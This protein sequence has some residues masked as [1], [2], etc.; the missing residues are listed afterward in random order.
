MATEKNSLTLAIL[1]HNNEKFLGSLLESILAQEDKSFSILALNNGSTDSSSEIMH[2]YTKR[3]KANSLSL[4]FLSS[5]DNLGEAIG[6]NKLASTC[7]TD[8]ISIIH[9]DDLLRDDYTKVMNQAII[10]QDFLDLMSPTLMQIDENGL[11]GGMLIPKWSRISWVNYF[12][13]SFGNP[14]LMPGA[15]FSTKALLSCSKVTKELSGLLFNADSVIWHRMVL[16]RPQIAVVSSAIYFYRRT[17]EQSSS[18][19]LNSKMLARARFIKLTNAPTAI[20]KW[21]VRLGSMFDLDFLESQE[22]YFYF[23]SKKGVH[24]ISKAQGKLLK[25]IYI[26]LQIFAPKAIRIFRS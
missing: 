15:L 1:F 9:G 25:L 16:G 11:E 20:N 22:E 5:N 17:I 12:M 23:L 8:Y 14:G 26:I 21:I 4:E 10:K 19:S 18:S 13:A 2:K 6:L 24:P 3:L 7:K